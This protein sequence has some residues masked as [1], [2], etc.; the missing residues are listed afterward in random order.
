ARRDLQQGSRALDALGSTTSCGAVCGA[1]DLTPTNTPP[2]GRGEHVNGSRRLWATALCVAGCFAAVPLA[3]TGS[4]HL[5]QPAPTISATPCA[6]IAS[7]SAAVA[8]PP[9]MYVIG[10][11]D[12]LNIQ[13]W[14]QDKMSAHVR[15]R[16]DGRIS[17]PFVDDLEAAGK[18]PVRLARALEGALKSGVV[19]PWVTVIVDQSKPLSVS[20]LGEVARPGLQTLDTGSG[21][22]QAL[23]A[24]GGLTTFAH[25][26]R[27]FVLRADAHPTRTRFSYED[28]TRAAGTA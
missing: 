25:K 14:D 7:A 21:I 24:S 28:I 6:E 17:L 22:A 4:Q 15:V 13:V 12:V 11:G 2:Q 5:H 1:P 8:E 27:I 19:P 9:N 16:T 26:S 18:T 10:V 23:A 20:V 3:H